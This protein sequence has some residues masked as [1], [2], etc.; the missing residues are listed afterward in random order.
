MAFGQQGDDVGAEVV[1]GAA[2]LGLRIA[3]ADDQQVGGGAGP[4]RSAQQGLV[5]QLAGPVDVSASQRRRSQGATTKE[6]SCRL[7][8]RRNTASGAAGRRDAAGI[9]E[10]VH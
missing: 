1:A 5:L 7:S 4:A 10:L 2:V 8:R 3:Q 9:C 6:S